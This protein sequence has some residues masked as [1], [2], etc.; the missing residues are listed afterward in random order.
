MRVS[1][2]SDLLAE[3]PKSHGWAWV[4]SPVYIPQNTLPHYIIATATGLILIRSSALL[5]YMLCQVA[6]DERCGAL[7]CEFN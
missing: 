2:P 4:V 6:V 3:T 1:R 7:S 5:W